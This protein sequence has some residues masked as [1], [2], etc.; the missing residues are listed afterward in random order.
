M[1]KNHRLCFTDSVGLGLQGRGSQTTCPF[2]YDVTLC[3][4]VAALS[5]ARSSGHIEWGVGRTDLINGTS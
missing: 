5:A 2:N 3:S 1:L 4:S